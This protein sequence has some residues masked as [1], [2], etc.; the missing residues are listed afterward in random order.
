M[1]KRILCLLLAAAL[2]LCLL[3]AAA[4][5]QGPSFSLSSGSV[6]PG[7]SVTL[8]VSAENNPGIITTMLYLYYD[9]AVFT[10]DPAKDVALAFEQFGLGG[11]MGN[12]IAAH[13]ATGRYDGKAGADGTLVLWYSNNGANVTRNGPMFSVT[14]H[15]ASDAKAGSYEI[16]LGYSPREIQNQAFEKLTPVLS[17]GTVRVEGDASALPEPPAA[18]AQPEPPAQSE[19]PVF[20][21]IAGTW[22]EHYITMAAAQGLVLGDNHGLYRPASTMTRAEFVMILWRSQGSPK[23]TKKATFTDIPDAWYQD[24]IAWA[25]ETGIVNGMSPGKFVP[26]GNVTRQQVVTV[27]HRLC[28]KPKGM[29]VLFASTYDTLFTD[30]KKIHDWAKDAVYWS[31]YREIYCGVGA[32]DPGTLLEPLADADRSQIAVMMVRYLEKY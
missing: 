24:P 30:S 20:P 8:T 9:T 21:D 28:G 23:P 17:G 2:M 29:E 3:P 1:K 19:T 25:E 5:A 18:P 32:A 22:A 26:R 16:G 27:L 6:T 15:A 14:L 11:V 12:T 4:A 13:K 31:L 10:V 7:S